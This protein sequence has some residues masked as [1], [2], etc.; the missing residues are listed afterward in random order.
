MS[1]V[2]PTVPAHAVEP[3]ELIEESRARAA[4]PLAGRDLRSAVLIGAA[5]VAAAGAALALLPTHRSPSAL[6]IGMLVAAY[7]LTS[8]V[9][10][11]VRTGLALP[12]ELVLVPMLFLLP[13]KAVPLCVAAGMLLGRLPELVR[14]KTHPDRALFVLV[15]SWYAVGPAL[16]L[17]VAGEPVAAWHRWPLYLAAL[18]AQFALD[19]GSSAT[20]EYLSLGVSPRS[21][22]PF[23]G[24]AYLVDSA[25][26][27]IGFV[28]ALAA[29]GHSVAVVVVLPLVGLLAV[30]ARERQAR[31]DHALELGH[32]YRGTAFLL[33]DVIEADDA[34][35]GSHSRDVVELVLGVADRLGL[36]ARER[37]D[38]E[39]AALLHDVGKVQIPS[40]LINKA[41]PLD[42]AERAL[43]NTHT[44]EGQRMLEK[45]GGLLGEVGRIVRSCH[46]HFDGRGYPDGFSGEEIPLA[47]R[48]VC[49][50]DAF[51]AM[52]TDRAYRKALPLDEAV[53]ELRRHSGTQFDPAVVEALVET[54]AA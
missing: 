38:A 26:A 47:A 36:D 31:I 30:F 13:A 21:Q 27:P 37:R 32:A 46:E 50:C 6:T 19:F 28:V 18:A 22:L 35:T 16:V 12:T 54:V 2:A 10:F 8:R 23:M 49:C 41:G 40:E 34:Y 43:I 42:P 24:W 4:Q 29:A 53:E 14:R 17:S 45:V 48:I 11:E 25:L 9:K 15:N 51:N 33:G 7:A 20:F 1:A 5:F 44:I 3:D 39:F 52:T